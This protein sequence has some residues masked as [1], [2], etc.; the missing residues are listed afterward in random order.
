MEKISEWK[1]LAFDTLSS[2]LKDI[3]S[4]LP[5]ILGALISANPVYIYIEFFY[6]FSYLMLILATFNLITSAKDK[7]AIFDYNDEVV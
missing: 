6:F 3:A 7:S 4:A 2:I 1:N 5:N